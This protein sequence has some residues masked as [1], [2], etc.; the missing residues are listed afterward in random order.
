MGRA[1]YEPHDLRLVAFDGDD[2]AIDSAHVQDSAVRV[3]DMA[4][5]P[6]QRRFA[7]LMARFDWA[8]HAAVGEKSRCR[9]ALRFERVR[10]VRQHGVPQ[11]KP[12]V[13]LN[14]LAVTFAW[15]EA[16]AGLVRLDFSGDAAIRL[17]VEC[18][19]AALADLGPRWRATFKPGHRT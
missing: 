6:E 10:D 14:L 9:A 11:T 13:V 17:D 3:G 18:L 4:W 1:H 12:D 2:L 16:P 5:L 8:A 15:T 19:E 7:L